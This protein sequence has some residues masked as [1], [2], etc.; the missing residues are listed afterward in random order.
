M[1]FILKYVNMKANKQILREY[2]Y[3]IVRESVANLTENSNNIEPKNSKEKKGGSLAKKKAKVLAALDDP[4][5][6]DA[7][8]MRRVWHPKTKKQEDAMRSEFSKK[9]REVPNDNGSTYHFDN[10]DIIQLYNELT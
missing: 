3:R 8:L 2:V 7:E 6:N 10:D 4:M 9:A 5:T 1:I